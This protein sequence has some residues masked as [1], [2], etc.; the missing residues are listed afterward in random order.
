[1]QNT[2]PKFRQSS[3][4]FEKPGILS[5][6]LKTLTKT[7][8]W[9]WKNDSEFENCP[10][11][12]YFLLKLRTRLLLTNVYK[13]VCRVFFLF[14]LHLELFAKIKNNLVSAQSCFTLLLITQDLN[15]IKKILHILFQKL[16][17]RK[18]AQNFSKKY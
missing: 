15:K 3:I 11:V 12:Q 6:N 4:V 8:F 17:S 16:L 9:I 2:I 10:T 5:R 13:R 7:E 14:C 18:R 1:M